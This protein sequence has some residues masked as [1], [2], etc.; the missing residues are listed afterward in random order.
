MVH[1]EERQPCNCV[2]LLLKLKRATERVS[3]ISSAISAARV[4]LGM[5]LRHRAPARSHFAPGQ[6][7]HSVTGDIVNCGGA[8]FP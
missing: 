5:S 4:Q 3:A 1:L 7:G 8:S 2:R 6:D